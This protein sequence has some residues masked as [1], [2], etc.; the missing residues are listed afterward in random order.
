MT[1]R[2]D[3]ARAGGVS[4]RL[5]SRFALRA[6]YEYEFWPN[7]PGYAGEP[8]HRLTPNGAQVGIAYSILRW[9]R[10][11]CPLQRRWRGNGRRYGPL[12]RNHYIG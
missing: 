6:E 11:S 8:N 4:Y 9:S 7:S 1:R 12:R 10:E 5:G 3:A 2:L